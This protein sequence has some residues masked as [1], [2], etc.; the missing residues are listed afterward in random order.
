MNRVTSSTKT[1]GP[2]HS[3]GKYY[4]YET[5]TTEDLRVFTYEWLSDGTLNEDLVLEARAAKINKE[6][7]DRGAALQAVVGTEVPYTKHEFLSRFTSQE[8]INIRAE[9]KV[10]PIVEDFM[11]MLSASGGVFMTLAREGINYLQFK[12][13]LTPERALEIGAD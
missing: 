7:E 2:V 8:R 4:V 12:G 1:L 13:I 5:H 6:L 10:D 3:G 11:E 9:A